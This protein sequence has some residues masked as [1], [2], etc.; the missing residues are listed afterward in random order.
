MTVRLAV[1]GQPV[2]HSRSPAMQNAAL[3]AVG[4]G[5]EWTYEAIEVSAGELGDLVRSLPERG[6]AGAN[7]TIPHKE[8]AL[9]LADEASAA[10][11]EIGAANTLTFKGGRIAAENTDAPGFLAALPRSPTRL[12][13]LVLGAGGSARAVAWA[14]SGAGARVDVWNRTPARADELVRSLAAAAAGSADDGPLLAPVSAEQARTTDYRLIVNCT[15]LGLD[16]QGGDPFEVLPLDPGRLGPDVA[17]IDLVYG[18]R[19]TELVRRAREL[20]AEVID[21]VEVLVRQG[22][23]S[24]RIWTGKEAPLDVMREAAR[25]ED[26]E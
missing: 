8:A 7:V 18:H 23:E 14:L 6:F 25:R 21:G 12:D 13:A 5:G 19:D 3:E 24:F 1:I 16:G 15:A 17:L 10:A 20:G 2:S 9:E 4:L 22:A 26:Q 11:R